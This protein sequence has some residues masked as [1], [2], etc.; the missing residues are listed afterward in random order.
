[1]H[2]TGLYKK[3]QT[4]GNLNCSRN[5][6]PLFVHRSCTYRNFRTLQLISRVCKTLCFRVSL[7]WSSQSRQIKRCTRK[8]V[9]DVYYRK[10]KEIH[11]F[12]NDPLWCLPALSINER[13]ERLWDKL[14]QS[15]SQLLVLVN[16]SPSL[17]DHQRLHPSNSSAQS[18]VTTWFILPVCKPALVGH[19]HVVVSELEHDDILDLGEV[20]ICW[21]SLHYKYLAYSRWM[22]F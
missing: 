22:A 10:K 16:L 18:F 7:I 2:F 8:N 13:K 12:L 4:L 17:T 6:P 21:P 1:M 9:I 5:K 11:W 20:K 14:H 15:L 19:L 3:E